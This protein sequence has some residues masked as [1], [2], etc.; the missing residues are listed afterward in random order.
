MLPGPQS[1]HCNHELCIDWQ[2]ERRHAQT[3]TKQTEPRP[4]EIAAF[5]KIPGQ[6]KSQISLTCLL[7]DRFPEKLR[8]G[9]LEFSGSK[10]A[11]D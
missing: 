3:A 11:V 7:Y 5:G 9:N 6:G 4:V 8:N 1:T 2:W 10:K